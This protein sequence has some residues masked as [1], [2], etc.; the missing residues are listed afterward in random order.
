MTAKRKATVREDVKVLVR[1]SILYSSRTEREGSYHLV[2]NGPRA[3][4]EKLD[5]DDLAAHLGDETETYV[6]TFLEEAGDVD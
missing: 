5:A 1:V 6:Q 4:L 2:L 3:M